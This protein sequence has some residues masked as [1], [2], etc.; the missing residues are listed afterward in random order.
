MLIKYGAI[1]YTSS[2]NNAL[3]DGI[4]DIKVLKFLIKNGARCDKD[5][6]D[7]TIEA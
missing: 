2:L 7:Y 5:T 6:L 4:K 1:C 3:D